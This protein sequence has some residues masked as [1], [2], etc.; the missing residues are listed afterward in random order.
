M[1]DE[2]VCAVREN[3]YLHLES[4]ARDVSGGT[5]SEWCRSSP[6]IG[7]L[8][9]SESVSVGR[10]SQRELHHAVFLATSCRCGLRDCSVGVHCCEEKS[11]TQCD[12]SLELASVQPSSRVSVQCDR[13]TAC[14]MSQQECR[15]LGNFQ[16]K[17]FARVGGLGS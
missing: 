13:S 12:L 14:E 6:D 11:R 3:T 9:H 16:L 10:E 1:S 17:L 5:R 7:A 4:C 15:H 2:R 8:L